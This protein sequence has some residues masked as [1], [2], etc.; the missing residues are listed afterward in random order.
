MGIGYRYGNERH[1]SKLT[2]ILLANKK[3]LFELFTNY[4]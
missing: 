1:V 3:K 4:K 2:E